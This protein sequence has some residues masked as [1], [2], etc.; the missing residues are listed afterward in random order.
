MCSAARSNTL[1]ARKTCISAVKLAPHAAEHVLPET[2]LILQM[3]VPTGSSE[4]TA[5]EV[6]PGV[7][8]VYGWDINDNLSTGGQTQVNR[9][10]DDNAGDSYVEFAQSW[11]VGYS[12]T[13]ELGSYAE[14]FMFPGRRRH[15]PQPAILR[16][17]LHAT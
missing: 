15:E 5:D 12:W 17:R 7:N 11:T 3:T 4:L 14:W 16:R 8:F 6:L 1:P 13:D 9:A 2:A 10:L